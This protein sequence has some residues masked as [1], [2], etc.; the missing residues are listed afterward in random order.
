M[1]PPRLGGGSA[2]C[3][4]WSIDVSSP[5]ENLAAVQEPRPTI[6]SLRLLQQFRRGRL[7]HNEFV[8]QSA[9]QGSPQTCH[10]S[11][12]GNNAKRVLSFLEKSEVG[13]AGTCVQR[14][15]AIT[16]VSPEKDGGDITHRTDPAQLLKIFFLEIPPDINVAGN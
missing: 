4:L 10:F 7:I 8:H 5:C 13:T 9:L 16:A 6:A 2:Q 3:M 14:D 1:R 15:I 11:Y 12:T